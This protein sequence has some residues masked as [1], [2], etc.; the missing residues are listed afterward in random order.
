MKT[1][2]DKYAPCKDALKFRRQH[3]TFEEAWQNCPRGDW[4]LWIAQKVGVNIRTLTLAKGYCAKTVIHLM[5]DERSVNAVKTSIRFGRYLATK[6]EL[7]AASAA[8]ADAYDA[9]YAVYDADAASYAAAYAASDA[10]ADAASYAAASAASDASAAS[11]A[12]YAA[13]YDAS[14]AYAASAAASDAD[15]AHAA[16]AAYAAADAAVYDAYAAR[17]RLKTADICRKYLTKDVLRLIKK[18][19]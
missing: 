13:V 16:S 11:A 7:Y 10:A 12:S 2:L 15:A 8:A 19:T 18:N 4:M 6:E 3:K 5:K 9:A 17:N 14:D 1:E